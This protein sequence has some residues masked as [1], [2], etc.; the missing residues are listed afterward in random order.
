MVTNQGSVL[1]QYRVS[2]CLDDS[3][4][5]I[6][7]KQNQESNMSLNITS[8][9]SLWNEIKLES[10]IVLTD[11]ELFSKYL[12]FF[13][14]FTTTRKPLLRIIDFTLLTLNE[15]SKAIEDVQLPDEFLLFR[16]GPNI[17]RRIGCILKLLFLFYYHL[18]FFFFFFF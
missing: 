15:E 2:W 11:V 9:P 5:D 14:E 12:V 10:S 18:F 1:K 16:P 13:G 17:V 7:R 8:F 4:F 3:F 6:L